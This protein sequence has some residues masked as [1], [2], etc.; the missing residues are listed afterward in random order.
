MLKRVRLNSQFL[1]VCWAKVKGK[2]RSKRTRR[3]ELIVRRSFTFGIHSVFDNRQ[4]KNQKSSSRPF[5]SKISVIL[6]PEYLFFAGCTHWASS[7]RTRILTLFYCRRS[8]TNKK[9][10][11]SK[12]GPRKRERERVWE[13]RTSSIVVIVVPFHHRARRRRRAYI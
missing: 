2:T 12:K 1:F 4:K 8:N 5:A 6:C 9:K 13:N 10:K 7:L 3:K 11:A